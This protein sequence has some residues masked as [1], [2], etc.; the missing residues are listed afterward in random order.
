[1]FLTNPMLPDEYRNVVEE[2]VVLEKHTIIGTGSTILPGCI[3]GE[4]TAVGSMSLVN[5][6][7]DPWGIYV[8]V[9]CRKIKDR[10]KNILE[11]EKAV[12]NGNITDK[13]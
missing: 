6:S 11:F 7:L 10:K 13:L 5:K 2:K 1:M 4:G 9:P 3:L 12:I 8:G